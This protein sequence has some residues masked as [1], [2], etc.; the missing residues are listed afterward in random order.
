MSGIPKSVVNPLT[1]L[2]A[3]IEKGKIQKP[4]TVRGKTFVLRSLND[5]D[6]TWRD[7]FVNMNGAVVHFS[8]QRSPTLAVATVA[9][10]GVPVE[11]IEG[12]DTV[13][14]S[15]PLAAREFIAS[16]A[17]YPIAYNLHTKVYSQLPREFL[18]ELYDKFLSEIEAPSRMVDEKDIKNS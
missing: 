12:L 16:T 14:E 7:Q 10:D 5:E 15:I 9:I 6:Y 11:Q 4:V 3:L 17:K 1:D 13:A 8:S 2:Y 18:E